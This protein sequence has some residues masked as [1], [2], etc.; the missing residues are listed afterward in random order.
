MKIRT[1]IGERIKKLRELS[2]LSQEKF[3]SVCN[4]DRTYINSLENGRRN[5]SVDTLG[6]ICDA[7]KISYMEFFDF[8]KVDFPFVELKESQIKIIDGRRLI[9]LP[10]GNDVAYAHYLDTLV[11]GVPI[12]ELNDN[13]QSLY[14]SGTVYLWGQTDGVKNTNLRRFSVIKPND[15]AIFT[16]K[17]KIIAKAI[18][19]KTT[20]NKEMS[21]TLWG[22]LDGKPWKNLIYFT[23][24]DELDI[25]IKDFNLAVGYKPKNIIQ[26]F[27][28]NIIIE[29]HPELISLLNL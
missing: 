12:N 27:T 13:L 3:A 8:D 4:L 17:G 21:E 19:L 6:K 26:G 15:V 22:T 20:I 24:L 18:V 10:V 14:P 9:T 1:E 25:N 11:N 23:K 5:I 28:T 2:G 7:F 16:R 29:E